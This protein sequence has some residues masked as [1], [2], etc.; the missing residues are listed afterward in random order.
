MVASKRGVNRA[1]VFCVLLSVVLTGLV[2]ADESTEPVKPTRKGVFSLYLENDSRMLKPNHNTDRHYTHGTKL[3]YVTQPDWQWLDDFSTWHFGEGS[4]VDTAT[5]F[6]FGQNIYT[7]DHVDDPAK[8][9]ADDR[10]FAGWMYTGMFVQRATDSV[11]DQFEL[12][13]GVIGPS[14]HAEEA[15]EWIHDILNSDD[16]I[17]WEDQLGDEFAIDVSFMRKHRMDNIIYQS[18]STDM[19]A[20]YGFTVGSV[21]RF[22][23]AGITMRYGFDLDGFGP[24]RLAL[25]SGLSTLKAP[26]H[27]GY[28]FARATGKAIEHNRFLTGL[29]HE[30]LMGEFQIGAVYTRKSVEIAYSQTFFTQEFEEQSGVD[31]F[32]ALTVSYRF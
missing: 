7:P 6:F 14:S 3:V 21:N 28:L 27:S 26:D 25:P 11:L 1:F 13:V 5:G 32:G 4:D 17:G 10:V 20:E 31:S 9:N 18:E 29:D 2:F 22:A 12:N 8:R 19:I 24:G 16:P 15:Q 30:P 23:Q